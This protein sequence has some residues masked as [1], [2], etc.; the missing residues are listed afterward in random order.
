MKCCAVFLLFLGAEVILVYM[1]VSN[2]WQVSVSVCLFSVTQLF[3]WS[4]QQLLTESV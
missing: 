3:C 4:D 1:F 2:I